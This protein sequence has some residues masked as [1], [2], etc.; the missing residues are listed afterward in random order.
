MQN[1]SVEASSQELQDSEDMIIRNRIQSFGPQ[2]GLN[3]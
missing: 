3:G 2:L 1:A